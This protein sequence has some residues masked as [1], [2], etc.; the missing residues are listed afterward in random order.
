MKYKAG[1]KVKKYN[2]YEF[3]G[4]VRSAF[5]NTDGYIVADFTK[6]T[7]ERMLVVECI[8]TGMLHVFNENNLEPAKEGL[9]QN[10]KHEN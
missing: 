6:T 1:D 9:G 5:T 7:G 10:K 2:G 4:E 8:N 3:V